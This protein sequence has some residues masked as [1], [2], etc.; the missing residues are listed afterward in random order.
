MR[1]LQE[2]GIYVL[3]Q[4][5]GRLPGAARYSDGSYFWNWDHTTYRHFEAIIDEF[6]QYPNTLGLMV[7]VH[8]PLRLLTSKGRGSIVHFK[9]YVRKKG[10]RQIPIGYLNLVTSY[11]I[12]IEIETNLTQYWDSTSGFS[13]FIRCGDSHSSAD[14]L[15]SG[16]QLADAKPVCLSGS[17]FEKRDMLGQYRDYSIP[18]VLVT[19]S[20][21]GDSEERQNQFSQVPVILGANASTVFSGWITHDW[22]YDSGIPGNNGKAHI[23][24]PTSF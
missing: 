16:L 8:T 9:D 19:R 15:L 20:G 12:S 6:Q 10:Y 24:D 2:A 14:F 7:S 23:T 5:T 13:D 18:T 21:C 1:M 22:F 11:L 17:D 3:I 4:L